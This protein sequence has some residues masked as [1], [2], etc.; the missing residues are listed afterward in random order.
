MDLPSNP[1][2]Q[3]SLGTMLKTTN[4]R[5]RDLQSAQRAICQRDV[6]SKSGNDADVTNLR[7][8]MSQILFELDTF[9]YNNILLDLAKYIH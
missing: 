1:G 5:M 4:E 9:I 2:C 3:G 8:N 7:I 6:T